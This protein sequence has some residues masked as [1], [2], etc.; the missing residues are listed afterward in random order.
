[1]PEI[2]PNENVPQREVPTFGRGTRLYAGTVTAFGY[3]NDFTVYAYCGP[4]GF[5]LSTHDDGHWPVDE[6]HWALWVEPEHV[7]D[8]VLALGGQRGDDPVKLLARQIENG[9]IKRS[10]ISTW[11]REHGVP[12]TS[13]SKSVS[14]L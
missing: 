4:D 9:V 14:N 3:D 1:M 2:D 6:L 13:D 12:F 10:A 5:E 11:I 7:P 8:L